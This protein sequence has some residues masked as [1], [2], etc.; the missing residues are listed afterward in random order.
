MV[1]KVQRVQP[2]LMVLAGQVQ[3]AQQ[4]LQAR[5]VH[6]LE[7]G[8]LVQ[9]V[10]LEKEVQVL[11]VRQVP[12]VDSENVLSFKTLR[13]VII[14]GRDLHRLRLPALKVTPA[15]V[16][17]LNVTRVVMELHGQYPV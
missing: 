11:Q 1:G 2:V 15:L 5:L 7:K 14:M 12:L 6:I 4:V 17:V 13:V 3:Q 9:L 10:Q 8:A 16:E